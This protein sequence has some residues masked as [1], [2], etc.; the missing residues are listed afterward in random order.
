MVSMS[1][2]LVTMEI[3]IPEMSTTA[4]LEGFYLWGF[5]TVFM[6]TISAV[7]TMTL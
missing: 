7:A 5:F 2:F 3:E 6:V 4:V 1:I